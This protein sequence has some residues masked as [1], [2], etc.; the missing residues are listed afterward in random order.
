VEVAQ[1]ITGDP[2]QKQL[3]KIAGVPPPSA[4]WTHT[5]TN[6]KLSMSG[7]QMYTFHWDIG[8]SSKS[9]DNGH[10]CVRSV[11]SALYRAGCARL[12]AV[13]PDACSS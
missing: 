12:C 4:D 11:R 9:Y 2:P 10:L 8:M 6:Q 5:Y 3:E 1:Q 13:M 7:F